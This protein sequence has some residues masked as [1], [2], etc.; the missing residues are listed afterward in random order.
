MSIRREILNY[1]PKDQRLVTDSIV[2]YQLSDRFLPCVASFEFICY[3]SKMRTEFIKF[4]RAKHRDLHDC[5][6]A[7]FNYG[8]NSH[9]ENHFMNF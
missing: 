8:E 6:H 7:F 4:N 2:N 3:Y 5:S 9:F 1:L